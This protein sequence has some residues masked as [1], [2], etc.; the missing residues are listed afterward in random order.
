MADFQ[1]YY[2]LMLKHTLTHIRPYTQAFEAQFCTSW[3]QLNM[4]YVSHTMYIDKIILTSE[5]LK[6]FPLLTVSHVYHLLLCG[7]TNR[8]WLNK[9]LYLMLSLP[10]CL[11]LQCCSIVMFGKFMYIS[12]VMSHS[13][14]C[15]KPGRHIYHFAGLC[16]FRK[17]NPNLHCDL[18][19]YTHV[20]NA[21]SCD[22]ARET[23]TCDF[24]S[25][26]H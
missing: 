15:C 16:S 21:L 7:R 10:A 12:H 6:L 2:V 18:V 13:R 11:A 8:V 20:L 1:C 22:M 14:Q 17:W 9:L 25:S 24:Y 5:C 3:P 4:Y 23:H 19:T 26:L